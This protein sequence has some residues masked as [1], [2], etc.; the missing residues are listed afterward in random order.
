VCTR[1][2][3]AF[4]T[5]TIQD[6]NL[7]NGAAHSGLDHP[8]SISKSKAIPSTRAHRPIDLDGPAVKTL[9]PGDPTFCQVDN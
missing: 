8:I 3:V 7:G 5:H 9:L 6:P 2:S 1:L 4:S